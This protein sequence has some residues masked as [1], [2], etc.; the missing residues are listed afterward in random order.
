MACT[1]H[2][3][4]TVWKFL[5]ILT[6]YTIGTYSYIFSQFIICFLN[7]D[8]DVAI[9]KLYRSQSTM[10]YIYL[11]HFMLFALATYI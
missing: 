9:V 4:N 7:T 10:F 8:I 5:S 6:I 11:Y 1:T 2:Q 3:R